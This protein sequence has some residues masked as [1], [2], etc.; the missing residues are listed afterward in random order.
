MRLLQLRWLSIRDLKK[1]MGATTT[2][3]SMK[4]IFI[5][6]SKEGVTKA[7]G[8]MMKTIAVSNE[9]DDNDNR[10]LNKLLTRISES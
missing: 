2:G 6:G 4:R 1:T 9:T 8:F 7:K 5:I 10:R 3:T